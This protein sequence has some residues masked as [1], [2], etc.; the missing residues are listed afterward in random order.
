MAIADSGEQGIH[1]SPKRI[2][3]RTCIKCGELSR[4]GNRVGT[5]GMCRLCAETL[6][7]KV[8]NK[9]WSWKA[10]KRELARIRGS[11]TRERDP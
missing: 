3:P 5:S 2:A 6:P 8:R 4:V 10:H 7:L 1:A 9:Y 11:H